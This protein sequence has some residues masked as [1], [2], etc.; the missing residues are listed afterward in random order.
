MDNNKYI[1]YTTELCNNTDNIQLLL[2][3]LLFYFKFRIK[4]RQFESTK[5]KIF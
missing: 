3:F 5:P 1:V 4:W 2:F